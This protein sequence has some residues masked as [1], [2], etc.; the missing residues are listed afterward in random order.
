MQ[1]KITIEDIQA[2]YDLGDP[3]SLALAEEA[4]AILESEELQV[5]TSSMY[6]DLPF[7]QQKEIY[8]SYDPEK[9]AAVEENFL[10]GKSFRDE[11]GQRY[12]VPMP[13]DPAQGDMSASSVVSNTLLRNVPANALDTIGALLDVA[14]GAFQAYTGPTKEGEDP[15][16]SVVG[17]KIQDVSKEIPKLKAG[18]SLTD[19]VLIGGTEFGSGGVFAGGL[20]KELGDTV[21]RRVAKTAAVETGGVSTLGREVESGI[22]TG[23]DSLIPFKLDPFD[24]NKDGISDSERL[25][26]T[27]A[28]LVFDGG[29]F[30]GALQGVLEVGVRIPQFFA[31][32]IA[33]VTKSPSIETLEEGVV[34]DVLE[35]ISKANTDP[36]AK[37][38][39]SNQIFQEIKNYL[40]TA[41]AKQ[42]NIIMGEGQKE[43][44]IALDVLQSLERNTNLDPATRQQIRNMM[45]GLSGTPEAAVRRAD[46]VSGFE[47]VISSEASRLAKTAEDGGP[48]TTT[49]VATDEL[50]DR[51]AAPVQ[52]KVNELDNVNA[53]RASAEERI[54]NQLMGT[55]DS[56]LPLNKLQELLV[57][58]REK[59]ITELSN[60]KNKSFLEVSDSLYSTWAK[61]TDKKNRLFNQVRGGK[62]NEDGVARLLAALE[63]AK[64]IVRDPIKNPALPSTP[65]R[66]LLKITARKTDD[67][68]GEFIET[69]EEQSARIAEFF[70]SQGLRKGD[71]DLS[72]FYREIRPKLSQMADDIATGKVA[73][74]NESIAA[75]RSFTDYIDDEMDRL[76]ESGQLVGESAKEAMDYYKTTYV[77]FWKDTP[78]DELGK[79]YRNTS[80]VT[81]QGADEVEGASLADDL[82]P[83]EIAE[84]SGQMQLGIAARP[85][86][87]PET[88]VKSPTKLTEASMRE[89]NNVI[90]DPLRFPSF[91]QIA[92]LLEEQGDGAGALHN[93]VYAD[94]ISALQIQLKTSMPDKATVQS[95]AERVGQYASVLNS[96]DPAKAREM[97]D[98]LKALTD[99][100]LN[101]EQLQVA[102][103]KAEQAARAAQ[104]EALD[105]V[106]G[107]FLQR[108]GVGVT[109]KASPRKVLEK[110]FNDED[111]AKL[112]ALLDE[113]R[114]TDNPEVVKGIQSYYLTVLREKVF[115][116]GGA[117]AAK[118]RTASLS[119]I[120][121]GFDDRSGLLGDKLK[122]VFEGS[123][124]YATGLQ[125]YG[126]FIRDQL[127]NVQAAQSKAGSRTA[128][129][130]TRG[131]LMQK[132]GD[133]AT[134][135][136]VALGRLNRRAAV[137]GS[138]GSSIITQ[139][140]KRFSDSIAAQRTVARIM[141]DPDLFLQVMRR[142]ESKEFRRE[143]TSPEM[144]G[145]I[146]TGATR[147]NIFGDNETALSSSEYLALSQQ[148]EQDLQA[149]P[150]VDD[151]TNDAFIRNQIEE[152]LK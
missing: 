38:Q 58:A 52:A 31:G 103:S 92:K 134:L 102:A 36:S 59:G 62:L 121:G 23:E 109:K 32:L 152:G 56:G 138:V 39:T 95:L 26:R 112:K 141:T 53:Q 136:T 108:S 137:T 16:M 90:Q 65:L 1:N 72:Y 66:N 127:Q 89:V 113:A 144:L 78:L 148:L 116:K 14:G 128:E 79:V 91:E 7:D 17:K 27:K 124:E 149:G 86:V 94:L 142:L 117:T 131:E 2:L 145:L 10:G 119:Q 4:L 6:E 81:R 54:V 13:A 93:I 71:M 18:D 126:Q 29:V 55:E 46:E 24:A 143:L 70:S 80:V 8:E 64:A 76:A 110:I 85:E 105:S 115:T 68:T 83:E 20:V 130:T 82:F 15:F 77:R 96:I 40:D 99:D 139:A 150:D 42:V 98:F 120:E 28:N 33:R 122:I 57:L 60:L 73:G 22:V 146:A 44:N 61:M 74:D 125:Q 47:E 118:S 11:T 43:I 48:P 9:D 37:V 106:L 133:F 19:A 100:S 12:M 97:D 49:D 111:P 21:V 35:I 123:E 88:L 3:E 132:L 135:V 45:D 5:P 87:Q 51:A 151:Q 129:A 25:L 101:I 30:S 104:Q 69:V 50:A 107:D 84:D 63:E 114:A 147:A 140:Q 41:D 34:S 75:L 67:E